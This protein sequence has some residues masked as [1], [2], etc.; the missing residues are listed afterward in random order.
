MKQHYLLTF[1][2]KLTSVDRSDLVTL[3]FGVGD[4][5]FGLWC[6]AWDNLGLVYSNM[7]IGDQERHIR[8][9]KKLFSVTECIINNEQAA[10]YLEVYFQSLHPPFNAHIHATPFQAS[11]WQ[12]TCRIPFG[13]TISYKQ[14]GQNINCASPRA[15]GQALASNPIAFLVPCH[16]VIHASGELGN[17]SMAKHALSQD[18]RKQ[19]KSDILQWEK[20]KT[21]K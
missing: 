1:D 9:L 21:V 10:E 15:V 13:K 14:L 20:M 4:S 16:R 18:R 11:V 8:Q 2:F 7:M 6:I 12:Q 17:Y 5:P 19:I 3:Y